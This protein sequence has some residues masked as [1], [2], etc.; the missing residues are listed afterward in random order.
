MIMRSSG[1][2]PQLN[3]E[4]VFVVRP[5][6]VGEDTSVETLVGYLGFLPVSLFGITWVFFQ[7]HWTIDLCRLVCVI[8]ALNWDQFFSR[9]KWCKTV[10]SVFP[11]T[12]LIT[13]LQASFPSPTHPSSPFLLT[14]F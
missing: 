2:G 3:L 8:L 13:L 10:N 4:Y 6:A 14:H 1:H 11:Q 7:H 9:G 12:K 5:M